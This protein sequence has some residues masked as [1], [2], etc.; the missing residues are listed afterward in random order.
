M[1]R[2]GLAMVAAASLLLLG[3]ALVTGGQKEIRKMDVKSVTAV[4]FVDDVDACARFWRERFG[5]QMVASV[6]E[7]DAMGFAMLQKGGATLM[8]QSWKSLEADVTELGGRPA[9]PTPSYL[10]MEVGDF[11]AARALL[12][13]VEIVVPQRDTFYG[14][15]EIAFRDPGGHVFT[16]AQRIEAG[17]D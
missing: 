5:F 10:F 17:G 16:F 9:S 15:R 14:M 7:G 13:G 6:P 8:Y 2:F 12:E 11:E 1:G 3:T 4:L